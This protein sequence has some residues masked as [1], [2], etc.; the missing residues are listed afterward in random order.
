MGRLLIEGH[1]ALPPFC[2]GLLWANSCHIRSN[3]D[4]S[5]DQDLS[6]HWGQSL[7]QR[8]QSRR[9]IL[10][11]GSCKRRSSPLSFRF[12]RDV[13]GYWASKL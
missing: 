6:P 12:L 2:D 1:P 3:L 13:D 9:A 8:R 11:H 4:I 5:G 7:P 10:L